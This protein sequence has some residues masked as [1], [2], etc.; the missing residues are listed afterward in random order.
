MTLQMFTVTIEVTVGVQGSALDRGQSY[1]KLPKV[2]LPTSGTSGSASDSV[3]QELE[4]SLGTVKAASQSP[5]NQTPKSSPR[6]TASSPGSCVACSV[7]PCNRPPT[8]DNPVINNVALFSVILS[9]IYLS[10]FVGRFSPPQNAGQPPEIAYVQT[11]SA[12]N[13]FPSAFYGCY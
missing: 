7:S 9:Q 4:Q 5:I 11:A 6:V 10:M 1:Y 13:I 2:A 8:P 3:R 12:C